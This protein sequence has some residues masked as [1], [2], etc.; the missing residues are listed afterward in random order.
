M[1][2]NILNIVSLCL[3]FF[4]KTFLRYCHM[5]RYFLGFIVKNWY[6]FSNIRFIFR[7]CLLL[8]G[9]IS[10]MCL[11]IPYLHVYW[12]LRGGGRRTY[13]WPLYVKIWITF[14]WKS[15]TDFQVILHRHLSVKIHITGIKYSILIFCLMLKH[16]RCITK[17]KGEP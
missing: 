4:L 11:L 12:W 17:R 3:H 2:N 13:K 6:T 14:T 8:L 15:N 10:D 1:Y 7:K 9:N 16:S 5:D